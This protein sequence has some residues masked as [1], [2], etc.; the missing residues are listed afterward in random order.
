VPRPRQQQCS[1]RFVLKLQLWGA[2]RLLAPSLTP[3]LTLTV[4][5]VSRPS[6]S[7]RL[8]SVFRLLQ[9]FH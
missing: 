1:Y 7:I 9:V 4:Y 6:L 5:R 8:R 2:S 3:V